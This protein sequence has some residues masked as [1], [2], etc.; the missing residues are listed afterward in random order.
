MST[1]IID[2]RIKK[3]KKI[4]TVDP[5]T[6]TDYEYREQVLKPI[7]KLSLDNKNFVISY[8]RN[9]DMIIA[10]FDIGYGV[11]EA[12]L[13]D[14]L[15][16]KAY[17]ELGL[18]PEKEYT[19]SHQ[20]AD[21]DESSGVYNLFITEPEVIEENTAYV[22]EKTSYID[23]LIPAPLLYKTLYTSETLDSSE[24]HCYIYFTMD[25]A[26]VTIYK[27][28]EFLYSKSLEYSLTQ[29]YEKYCAMI[30]E[31]VDKKE[32]FEI[33]ESEGL[34]ATDSDY[35]QNLMKMFGEI[36]LQINDIIIYTKRA[37][38][39]DVIQ[40]LF[41]GSIKSPIIGLGD[42][43]YNYLGIPTFNL[44]FNF[45]MKNDEW[46]V[47]QFQYMMVQSGLDYIQN[48]RKVMNLTTVP[49]P[50]V[51]SK[52]ASGQFIISATLSSLLALGVPIFYLVQSYLIDAHIL[53]LSSENANYSKITAKYKKILKEKRDI[54]KE[55]KKELAKIN[56]I[57]DGKAKTLTSIYNKKVDYRLKSGLLN[58][59]AHDLIEY[60]VKLEKI[61]SD[62]DNFTLSVVS[63]D[64]KK[65]TK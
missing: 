9:R 14:M 35:Q 28:G 2:P 44:D 11:D 10:S 63:D 31:K 55:N 7:E 17:D 20:K 57:F 36:F 54:I 64:D 25:D 18:D 65:I 32:F 59:F 27:N 56:N 46:Y 48:P 42:Y 47:D 49:R 52:R 13:D 3:F 12:E 4:I 24:S 21:S 1:E 30:G 39:I 23:L 58:K 43:G 29:I 33:L 41:L 26:F 6:H 34:K 8:I 50:P 45:G 61:S 38:G 16:M 37:Y 5:Y 19:I 15:Y 51:F 60:E 40:K 53:Q 62:E 22:L